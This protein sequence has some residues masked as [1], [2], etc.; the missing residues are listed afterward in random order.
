MTRKWESQMRARLGRGR[1][2]VH[3]TLDRVFVKEFP[4]CH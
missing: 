4:V 2:E 1:N 3:P